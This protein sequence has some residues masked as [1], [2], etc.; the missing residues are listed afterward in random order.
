MRVTAGADL[1]AGRIPAGRIIGDLEIIEIMNYMQGMDGL[2]VS[3]D[4]TVDAV[5]RV[6]GDN[7]SHPVRNYLDGLTL[8][9][10]LKSGHTL[11]VQN[12]PTE[13]ADTGQQ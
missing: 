8:G 1:C 10:H 9:N 12:R 5:R 13:G 7:S 11:S 6:A 3:K 4:T 2:H